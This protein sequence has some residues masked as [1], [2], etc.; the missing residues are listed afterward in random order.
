MGNTLSVVVSSCWVSKERW[1]FAKQILPDLDTTSLVE[2]KVAQWLAIE[3]Y[4][5]HPL[6]QRQ[7]LIGRF[8]P[9]AG[10]DVIVRE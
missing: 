6:I 9:Q 4:L 8:H 2:S 5:H 10:H 7:H 1:R 3:P